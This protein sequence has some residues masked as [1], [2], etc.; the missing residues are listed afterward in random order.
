MT[1]SPAVSVV[2]TP[3]RSRTLSEFTNTFRCRR[4]VPVSSQ[5]LRYK[6]DWLRSRSSSAA[7]TVCA[8]IESC[9]RPHST[10]RSGPGTWIVMVGVWAHGVRR[11]LSLAVGMGNQA[12]LEWGVGNHLSVSINVVGTSDRDTL[13]AL[14]SDAASGNLHAP[15]T[16]FK[17]DS[18]VGSYANRVRSCAHRRDGRLPSAL[19]GADL[20]WCQPRP[21][22]NHRC[23]PGSSM[24]TAMAQGRWVC[25]CCGVQPGWFI[26]GGGASG[27]GHEHGGFGQWHLDKWMTYGDIT[28]TF[29][30][31]SQ[32]RDFEPAT[33][34]LKILGR[35]IALQ[36]TNVVLV[37]DA[38]SATPSIVAMRYSR[39][40]I[41]RYPCR[42]R[43][44]EADTG[45]VR[46]LAV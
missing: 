40:T 30:L 27:G 37:D 31:T 4:T 45:T 13:E 44:C 7:R 29:E 18:R 5:T 9:A 28:L 26:R 38:D 19:T 41:L 25:W 10:L 17:M 6:A 8:E 1:T 15:R 33:T 3:S 11:S 39:P 21:L 16:E 32:S 42:C 43:D 34:V 14:A 35:E 23:V 12:V 36:G 20:C 2:S 46:V 24:I 22:A